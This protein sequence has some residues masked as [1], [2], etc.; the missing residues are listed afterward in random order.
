VSEL[1]SLVREKIG[2]VASFKQALIVKRLPKT[3]SGKIVRGTI[4]KISQGVPYTIP[5]TIDDPVTLEEIAEDLGR[6]GY[7]TKRTEEV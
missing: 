4:R 7:P 5:P 6:A 1:V 3:R 2:P